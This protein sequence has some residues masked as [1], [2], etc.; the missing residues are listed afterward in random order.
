MLAA[1]FAVSSAFAVEVV[2]DPPR[3]HLPPGGEQVFTA[4][5]FDENG[6]N[7]CWVLRLMRLQRGGKL[8]KRAFI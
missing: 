1:A 2:V 6:Q 3:A 4:T 5:A 8:R 7:A